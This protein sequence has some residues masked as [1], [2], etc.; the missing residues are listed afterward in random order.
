MNHHHVAGDPRLG[1]ANRRAFAFYDVGSRD[2][3]VEAGDFAILVGASSRDIRL[4]ATLSLTT[5]DGTVFPLEKDKLAAY[6]APSKAQGFP[7]EAFETLL[8]RP[9]P[10]NAAEQKGNYT[11]NTPIGEMSGSAIGRYLYKM[12][13]DQIAKMV[14]GKEDTPTG[15]LMRAMVK[16]MPLRS[17]LMMGGAMN[18]TK[19][20]ALLLMIN[21]HLLKGLV[22]FLKNR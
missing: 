3:V 5:T 15:K 12:L 18:R 9:V 10:T 7:Q 13:N 21:G 19:L 22:A 2:W 17:M 8:G 11:L 4:A 16:E 6:Y 1:R 20:E 14:Q